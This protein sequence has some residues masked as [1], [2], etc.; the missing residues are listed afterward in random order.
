MLYAEVL[1]QQSMQTLQSRPGFLSVSFSALKHSV[2]TGLRHAAPRRKVDFKNRSHFEL[3]I[4]NTTDESEGVCF[5]KL[6]L[7]PLHFTRRAPGRR[8]LEVAAP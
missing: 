1:L 6:G 5:P 8:A 4:I 3:E 2:G 7:H